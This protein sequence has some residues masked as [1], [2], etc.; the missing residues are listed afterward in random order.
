MAG[1]VHTY[2]Q[3]AAFVQASQRTAGVVVKNQWRESRTHGADE[4]PGGWAPIVRYE[5]ARGIPTTFTSAVSS[6]PSPAYAIGTE[7]EVLYDVNDPDSAEISDF[8]T[9][10]LV[11]LVLLGLGV[12]AALFGGILVA[13]A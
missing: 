11:P 10:W 6:Y 9:L 1:S 2:W 4:T 7:V 8:L 13:S 12:V 5:D 3:Q